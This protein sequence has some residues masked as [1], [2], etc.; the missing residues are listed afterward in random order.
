MTELAPHDRHIVIF[1]LDTARAATSFAAEL[2]GDDG[3][4]AAV[5]TI[6]DKL[7]QQKGRNREHLG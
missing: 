3:L 7:D 2:L 6:E 1:L 5:R 4:R